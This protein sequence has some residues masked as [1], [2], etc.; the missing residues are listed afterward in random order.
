MHCALLKCSINIWGGPRAVDYI[1]GVDSV[2]RRTQ[3]EYVPRLT[4]HLQEKFHHF[5]QTQLWLL[6]HLQTMVLVL[7]VIIGESTLYA[8][9][10]SPGGARPPN[11]IFLV[12]FW[13]ENAL[14][15]NAFKGYCTRKCLLAKPAN[16]LCQDIF[17]RGWFISEKSFSHFLYHIWQ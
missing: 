12:H 10:A 8:P 15:G 17:V 2:F 14:S 7:P 4:R 13:S 3:N 6:V 16:R 5:S 11:D 9:P 1:Y